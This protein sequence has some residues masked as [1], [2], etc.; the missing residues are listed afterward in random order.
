VVAEIDPV[1]QTVYVSTFGAANGWAVF[2][3]D[4]CNA[5]LQAGCTTQGTLIGDPSG[6]NDAAIDT[7]NAT[8]YAANYDNTVSAFDLR[9]CN[10]AD[11]GG[12]AA[13]T[14]GVV[15]PFPDPAFN[16]NTVWI[17]VDPQLRTVYAVYNRDDTIV[18]ID[19]DVCTGSDVAACA[20][21]DPPSIH[22]G[23]QP[24]GVVLD[25]TTQTLYA[26]DQFGNGVSVI[27]AARCNAE[28]TIGC[29]RRPPAVPL[30]APGGV[31]VNARAHTAYVTAGSGSLALIDTRRCSAWRDQG[32]ATPP[33]TV[34][35]GDTPVAVAA[36]PATHTIYVADYGTGTGGTV[37]VP[38][39]RG[40]ARPPIR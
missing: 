3:A 20:T 5:T 1:T 17:A 16:E 26:A 37:A 9:H 29:R 6:P 18:A 15:T 30:P 31:A 27:D 39:M 22:T 32:C 38:S 19:T 34:A 12:C 4:A 8:L 35:A 7:A 36:S 21:L 10:A 40:D 13:Q 23:Q 33:V 25:P 24:E 2:A 14:A 28:I 11:L